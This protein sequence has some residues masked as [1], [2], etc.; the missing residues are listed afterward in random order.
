VRFSVINL[1][2]KLKQKEGLSTATKMRYLQ[3]HA[4]RKQSSRHHQ[5]TPPYP[6]IHPNEAPNSWKGLSRSQLA[7][8]S[9]DTGKTL[10]NAC[11]G[12]GK[13]AT[14][15]GKVGGWLEKGVDSRQILM[16]TFTRKAAGEM[17]HR[18]RRLVGEI[19][20]GING[21][22][23]HSIALRLLRNGQMGELGGRN[24][25]ILDPDDANRIWGRILND[26]R[27]NRKLA[28]LAEATRGLAVNQMKDPAEAL[29][30]IPDFER[31]GHDLIKRYQ[32]IKVSN[33]VADFDDLLVMWDKALDAGSG[34]RGQWSHVM[35]DEFQDNSEIQY[36]ILRKL[37]AQEIFAV[38][39][40]NQCIYSFRGSATK[41]MQRFAEEHPEC[42]EF[43][44]STNYRSG[45]SILNTAN[46]AMASGDKPVKLTAAQ[47][48][49]GKVYQYIL[50]TARDEADFA[51]GVV[52]WR[53]SAGSKANDIAILF[54]SR[55]QSSQLEIALNRHQIPYKKYG[56]KD[57]FSASDVKDFIALLKVWQ[58]PND[59]IAK[60][61]VSLLFPQVGK[62]TA[63]KNM[64]DGGSPW[65]QKAEQAKLWIA[66]AEAMGWPRGGEFL[67]TKIID[68]FPSNY[69]KDFVD[70]EERVLEIGKLCSEY[71]TLTAML[72]YHCTGEEEARKHPEN[73]ITISTIH[74][75]KGLEWK[76]VVV[77]GASDGQ[78]PSAMAK[79]RDHYEEERRLFYVATTR[80]KKF[81]CYTHATVSLLNKIQSPCPFLPRERWTSP[82]RYGA[83]GLF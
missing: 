52:K 43:T 51:A 64:Q 30:R 24:T 38:G 56:G 49:P 78:L 70:R 58:N 36:S 39:D 44:I 34:G 45:Q 53:L 71:E 74:S 69:P 23:Y 50:P 35:V 83:G 67:S 20:E 18:L 57:I 26:F 4:R 3:T 60:T 19:S 16:L 17:S 27:L 25:S 68:L 28:G 76:D 37:G 7:A 29:N 9:N 48:D 81:L 10:V 79:G 14:A 55:F 41:L 31:R 77:F 13:T 54:R 11:A 5:N 62:K 1:L 2:G 22:T 12:S 40:P 73:C 75:S 47:Q 80:A 8:V 65:P 15:T 46:T 42:R 21:G 63:E 59:T 72:D 33:G 82:S 61:R 6:M 66:Q 32:A